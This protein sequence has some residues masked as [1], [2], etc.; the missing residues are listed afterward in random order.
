MLGL[1]LPLIGS[2]GLLL[3]NL[4]LVMFVT[5]VLLFPTILDPVHDSPSLLSALDVWQQHTEKI[6]GRALVC[7]HFLPEEAPAAV[8]DALLQ[9]FDGYE[10]PGTA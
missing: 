1:I 9:F 8:C 2:V 7:G 6:E 5:E 3:T 10:P 4:W